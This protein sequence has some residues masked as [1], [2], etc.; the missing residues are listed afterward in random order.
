MR[1]II[2]KQRRISCEDRADLGFGEVR[3]FP[4]GYPRDRRARAFRRRMGKCDARAEIKPIDHDP[5][6]Q[7]TEDGRDERKLYGR[8]T[9]LWERA[10]SHCVAGGYGLKQWGQGVSRA[11]RWG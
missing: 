2:G 1:R 5:E 10:V 8:D 3:P 6:H 7:D 4:G 9:S 11:T